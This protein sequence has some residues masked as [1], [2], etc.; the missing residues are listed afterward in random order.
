MW[1]RYLAAATAQEPVFKPHIMHLL[2][3][4]GSLGCSQSVAR[5]CVSRAAPDSE[6][7][8]ANGPDDVALAT[9]PSAIGTC[10]ADP[11]R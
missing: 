11:W 8:Q 2:D 10:W 3:E 1:D 7:G 5:Q 6:A 4:I 9:S